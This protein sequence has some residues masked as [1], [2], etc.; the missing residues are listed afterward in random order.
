MTNGALD[1]DHMTLDETRMKCDIL[2]HKISLTLVVYWSKGA[3][4]KADVL[5]GSLP[6]EGGVCNLDLILHRLCHRTRILQE[7][8]P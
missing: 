4:Y 8:Q 1:S 5:V 3:L 2:D 6:L 7:S